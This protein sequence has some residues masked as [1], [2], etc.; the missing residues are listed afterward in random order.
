MNVLCKLNWWISQWEV[1]IML[2]TVCIITICALQMLPLVK[3]INSNFFYKLVL[4]RRVHYNWTMLL[5]SNQL[6]FILTGK[7]YSPPH[8]IFTKHFSWKSKIPMCLWWLWAKYGIYT[9][10]IYAKA[11]TFP[12]CSMVRGENMDR[13][14]FALKLSILELHWNVS[15]CQIFNQ[16]RSTNLI[17][18]FCI[19]FVC[20]ALNVVFGS[21]YLD[22]V[23]LDPKTVVS[24]LAAS[25]LFQLDGLLEKCCEVMNSTINA[26]VCS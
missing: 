16:W 24:V 14:S 2:S 13:I 6:S 11:H 22:E 15:E 19:F 9:K 10:S 4:N 20:A 25:T 7:N 8:N 12:V 1:S 17:Y 23:I 21:L 18:F 26:E 5:K 3:R